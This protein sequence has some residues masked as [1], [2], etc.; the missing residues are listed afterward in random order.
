MRYIF[1]GIR[2]EA[3]VA[4]SNFFKLDV[5]YTTK[6]SRVHSYAKKNKLNF[7]LINKK[8]KLEIFEKLKKNRCKVI[9]SA[10]FPYIFPKEV[11]KN[12]KIKINSHPSLLPMNKGLSP[13]K[14]IYYSNKKKIGVTL[15]I[16]SPKV[17]SGKIIYQDFIL[18]NKLPISAI[19]QLVFKF[20]EPLVISKGIQKIIK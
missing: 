2:E 4:S 8:N 1:A 13:I 7:F 11:L 6:G 9:L 3:L 5:I 16:M 14:E 12:F 19:Y 18:K 10:G 15:H 17:D 20:L